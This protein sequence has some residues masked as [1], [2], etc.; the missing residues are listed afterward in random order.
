MKLD[1]ILKPSYEPQEITIRVN[2]DVEEPGTEER[3]RREM[4]NIFPIVRMGNQ[5][6][7]FQDIKRFELRVGEEFLPT[8]S[9]QI[10]CGRDRL[11]EELSVLLDKL[12][13]FLGDNNDPHFI[14]LDMLI[15]TS[16]A[17]MN[18]FGASFD[19]EMYVPNIYKT[20]IRLFDTLL[21]ALK[22]ISTYQV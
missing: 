18:R 21:D 11:K 8:M 6:F 12:T 17:K 10:D 20:H 14:K 2:R 15:L 3:A 13:F 19:C 5:V 1:E 16:S 4:G 7:M 22:E 9:V